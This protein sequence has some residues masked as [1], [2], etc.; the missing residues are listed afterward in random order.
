MMKLVF[1]TILLATSIGFVAPIS[2]V[3][4]D[5]KLNELSKE[6]DVQVH[7]GFLMRHQYSAPVAAKVVG[8]TGPGLLDRKELRLVIISLVAS[9]YADG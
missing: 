6:W 2:L 5:N 9:M 8:L 3:H 7:G 4:A 1:S